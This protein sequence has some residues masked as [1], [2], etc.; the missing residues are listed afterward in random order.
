MIDPLILWQMMRSFVMISLMA[1]GGMNATVSAVLHEIVDNL[2]WLDSIEFMHLFTVAQI[3]PG[4]NVVFISLLGWQIAGWQGLIVATLSILTLPC[5]L[6]FGVGRVAN[7]V[8]GSRGFRLLQQA[9]VPIAVGLVIASGLDL[10]QAAHRGW[11]TVIITF[12]NLVM[13][14]YTKANPIWGLAASAL[15][16]VIAGYTGLVHFS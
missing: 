10:A 3:T 4:P 1:I 13:T 15:V 5:L 8:G 11:L 2:H 6:A 16:S 9:L 7:R 14:Y 12:A